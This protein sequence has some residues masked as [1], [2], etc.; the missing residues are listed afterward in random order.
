MAPRPQAGSRIVGGSGSTAEAQAWP[1]RAFRR[2][3][4]PRAEIGVADQH[5]ALPSRARS[6]P[7]PVSG[8]G[9]SSKRMNGSMSGREKASRD[10]G[11]ENGTAPSSRRKRRRHA[12]SRSAGGD[13][14]GRGPRSSRPVRRGA[15]I[16]RPAGSPK[17]RAIHVAP[18]RYP[19]AGIGDGFKMSWAAPR[20][21]SWRRVVGGSGL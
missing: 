5:D 18:A 20:L 13:R 3:S 21:R 10:R 9:R 16:E 17:R 14:S 8:A 1:P 12:G 4:L 15:G 7:C 6:T 19:P 2:V 11:S